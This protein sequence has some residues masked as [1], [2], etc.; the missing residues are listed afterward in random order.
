[1]ARAYRAFLSYSHADQA[2]GERLFRAIDGYRPPRRL[3]GKE[4]RRGPVPERLYPV[5]RDREELATSPDLTQ[6]IRD[7]LESAQDLIVLCSPNAAKSVW[8]NRE[9]EM[10]QALG[11]GDRIHAALLDGEPSE[12]LPP[13]LMK[14]GVAP[15]AA[16]LRAEGD[17]WT[18]G[19]L[20]VVAGVL[21]LGFGELK[22]RE[23][24][25]ARARARLNG[26][27]AAVFALLFVVAA[28]AGW[29]AY[30]EQQRANAELARAEAAI[31]AAAEGLT[32][33]TTAVESGARTGAIR[34]GTASALLTTSD[35]LVE[36][37]VKLAPDDP[38]LVEEHGRLLILFARHFSRTGDVA[39]AERAA[40]RARTI[41]GDGDASEAPAANAPDAS[42][43]AER[44]RSISLNEKGD[45]LMKAGD[46]AAA[47][48][49]YAESLA[50]RRE[51]ARAEPQNA[52]YAR[53]VFATLSRIGLA[54]RAAG[55]LDAAEDAFA[56]A[57][58]IARR[59]DD[60]A[61]TDASARDRA[62]SLAN[63]GDVARRRND[64]RRALEAY[65]TAL[66][67]F[68][69]LVRRDPE[70]V[71]LA[72]DYSVALERIG[73]LE[74]RGGDLRRARDAYERCEAIRGRL[75]R[76]DRGDLRAAR[77]HS[78]CLAKVGDARA[79]SGDEAGA[80]DAYE[81]D[82]A[83][84]R[85]LSRRDPNNAEWRRDLV[86]SNVKVATV[87][88]SQAAER[89]REALDLAREMERSGVLAE[90]DR[91]MIPEIRKRLAAAE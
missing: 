53:D 6:E 73:E 28:G 90:A 8:V 63:V 51:A 30:V 46:V 84:S 7:A 71:E 23:A 21:G 57:L 15:V 24:A 89:Y 22:D 35:A 56:E 66:P 11:K 75:A 27:L 17:G 74:F 54:A 50:L 85:R 10:F 2:A 78:V 91:W 83:I 4:T 88:P 42:D 58:E 3:R 72:R 29:R 39:A 61:P 44:M 19:P 9:I 80:L 69:R 12:S 67:I 49:A 70:N 68:R 1:M 13:A 36:R 64:A 40:E 55:D 34:S 18:D 47:R 38:K 43:D 5:F 16:D 87:D 31:L 45:A 86:I 65:E 62:V 52:V 48:D 33:I 60:Q 76:R 32:A 77:D 41:L 81:A 37:V 14:S 79:R 26:A 25:R 82:L 59:L 20:K